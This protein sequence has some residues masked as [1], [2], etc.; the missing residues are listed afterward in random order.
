MHGP[1]CTHM[2][3][4]MHM[5]THGHMHT[6]MHT[7][8]GAHA[9]GWRPVSNSGLPLSALHPSGEQ[10]PDVNA[11]SQSGLGPGGLPLGSLDCVLT[12]GGQRRQILPAPPRP[13]GG[14]VDPAAHA[15]HHHMA[16]WDLGLGAPEPVPQR[17]RAPAGQPREEPAAAG[18]QVGTWASGGR[19]P[20]LLE[21]P[22][23]VLGPGWH[24]TACAD[25]RRGADA[26]GAESARTC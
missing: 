26:N 20:S 25:A 8:T 2:H 22:G 17:P 21:R 16:M 7:C 6:H 15:S 10:A 18:E 4:C 5:S 12:A 23:A 3:T 24:R 1:I 19:S 13:T 14:S 9:Q 11:C